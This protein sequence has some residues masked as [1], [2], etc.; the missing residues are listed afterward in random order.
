M[1]IAIDGSRAFLQQRTGIEEYS[2]QVIRHLRDELVDAQVIV[3]IRAN[4]EIDFDLPS[5]WRIKKLWAPRF[6]THI[7]L[8][9][10]MLLH[11]P[12]VLFVPAHTVP[13]I[14]PDNTVVTIHGLEYEIYPDAYYIW[15]RIAMRLAIRFSCKVA[16]TIICVS[17]NTKRD[18]I[19]LYAVLEEK[20]HVIYEGYDAC[21]S[22]LDT[23]AVLP[24]KNEVSARTS[25][26]NT[27]YIL[28]IGRL[29]ERKNI[30]RCIKAFEILKSKHG[31][32]HTL[33]LAGKPGYRY[34]EIQKALAK[35]K[36]RNEIIET[37][38]VSEE[39]KRILLSNASVF[40]FATLYEGFGI[41]VLE[42][43]SFGIPV[44][45]SKTSSLPEI[46]GNGAILV[47]PENV[48]EITDAMH[49]LI[50]NQT[51]KSDILQKG[52]DNVRRFHWQQCASEIAQLLRIE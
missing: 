9:L 8:S 10:E 16:K 45:T 4:Q 34:D 49:A 26:P 27:P 38:F 25:L 20:L 31:V 24:I 47:D 41:P 50:S 2:Y 21:E 18:V 5:N 52:F 33:F 15:S 19:R 42:A 43:Q 23:T 35:S 14:H 7:R 36:Y 22:T 46:A 13:L 17:K 48:A 32:P 12:D 29:E 39:E 30:V 28:F 11:H 37:G 6:W 44:V 40:F 3:Y 51:L 1:V